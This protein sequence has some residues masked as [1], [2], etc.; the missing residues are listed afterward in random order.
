M[1]VAQY[2]G[3][4]MPQSQLDFVNIPLE[5]DIELYVDPYGLALGADDFS[6]ACTSATRA[7]FGSVLELIRADRDAE[8]L[9]LLDGLHEPNDVHLGESRGGLRGR[10]VGPDQAEG[11]HG[12]LKGSMAVRT[13]FLNDLSDCELLIAGVGRDKISDITINTIRGELIQWTQAQC[14]LHGI[15][16]Q[17][18]AS[19]PVWDPALGRWRIDAV[20]LPTYQGKAIVLVPKN[21]VRRKLVLDHRTYYRRYVLSFLQEDARRHPSEGLVRALKAPS[22]KELERRHPCSKD[23]LYRFSADNPDVLSRYKQD[24]ASR[25][26]PL[27]DEEISDL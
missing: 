8:A 9:T 20:E 22:K 1:Q 23:L 7:F 19:G 27:T 25:D 5:T 4:D 26:R 10:G 17:T 24:A 12:R 15:R 16:V 21:I 11:I 2:F 3:I 18:T 14:R 6:V 13:G